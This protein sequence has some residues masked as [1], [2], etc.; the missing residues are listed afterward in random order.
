MEMSTARMPMTMT[1]AVAGGVGAGAGSGVGVAAEGDDT[2]VCDDGW[3][4]GCGYETAEG[5]KDDTGLDT[6]ACC[7]GGK[8]FA[9]DT[10]G[11]QERGSCVRIT[12]TSPTPSS[13]RVQGNESEEPTS[14]RRRAYSAATCPPT[15]TLF[16]ISA[17]SAFQ[18]AH[19]R[20]R[21]I[22][23]LACG[24]RSRKGERHALLSSDFPLL[25][26]ATRCRSH[27]VT[28]LPLRAMPFSSLSATA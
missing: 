6:A 19:V 16:L 27:G 24:S 13:P 11:G 20:G 22:P 26:S 4:V 18:T 28:A 7:C 15:S 1:E 8:R 14:R 5:L 12:C 3:D 2:A 21:E 23:I 25:S 9:G 17:L 10:V